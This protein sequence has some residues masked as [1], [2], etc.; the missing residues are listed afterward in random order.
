[1]SYSRRFRRRHRPPPAE[2][3]PGD[4]NELWQ[5][6][7]IRESNAQLR[8]DNPRQYRIQQ[9]VLRILLA[10]FL[11]GC[12]AAVLWHY[13]GWDA[14][15]LILIVAILFG[16]TQMPKWS[17][18]WGQGLTERHNERIRAMSRSHTKA[19]RKRLRR[20]R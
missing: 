2:P 11:L 18:K 5:A 17:R 4:P 9:W 8:R 12:V 20:P 19:K 6:S 10:G 13:F 3:A 15:I 14:F 7:F 1:M 16:M